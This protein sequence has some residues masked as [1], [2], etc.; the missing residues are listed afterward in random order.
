MELGSSRTQEG[1]SSANA[2][3]QLSTSRAISTR[4]KSFFIWVSSLSF[5]VSLAAQRRLL[6][7]T[8]IFSEPRVQTRYSTRHTMVNSVVT[9][10]KAEAVP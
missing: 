9:V 8:L 3:Q 6:P 7:Y 10:A 4:L 5:I 1:F 2:L